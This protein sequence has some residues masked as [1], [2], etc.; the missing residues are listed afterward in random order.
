MRHLLII[1]TLFLFSCHQSNESNPSFGNEQISE[2]DDMSFQEDMPSAQSTNKLSKLIKSGEMTFDVNDL[3][4]SKTKLDKLVEDSNGYFEDELYNSRTYSNVYTLKIRV[5]KDN[6]EKLVADI[7]QGMGTLESKNIRV[8]DVTEEY[9]DLTI[10]LNNNL[11][12]VEQYQEIL[13]KAKTIKEILEVKAMI[14]D[15]EANI[16]SQKGRIKYLDDQVSYS[17]LNIELKQTFD[18]KIYAGPSFLS[19]ISK[20]FKNGGN[21]FLNFIVGIVHLWPFLVLILFIFI[22][23]KPLLNLIRKKK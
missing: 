19:R 5:P 2:M 8:K 3:G 11:A 17:I 23:R 15:L 9:M 13:K 18:R 10:R 12:Y 22:G 16:D 7:E 20:A 6:F 14:Q 1:S 4:S 21:G